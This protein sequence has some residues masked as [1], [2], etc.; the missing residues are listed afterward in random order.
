MKSAPQDPAREK[1]DQLYAGPL[2]GFVARRNELAKELALAGAKEAA[3]RVKALPKPVATAWVVNRLAQEEAASLTALRAA[4]DELRRAQARGDREALRRASE[5]RHELV[6]TL[7][8]RAGE[9]LREGGHQDSIQARQRIRRTLE[10][11]AA[12]GSSAALDPPPGRLHE[13][14]EPPGFET[15]LGLAGGAPPTPVPRAAPRELARSRRAATSDSAATAAAKKAA[16][17]RR[18]ELQR[19]ATVAAEL[20]EEARAAAREAE[21]ERERATRRAEDAER[22]AARQ[23][24]RL[25]QAR[26]ARDEAAAQRRVA[27]REAA[28]AAKALEKRRAELAAAQGRLR[29]LA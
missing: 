26:T 15:L 6:G 20:V 11:I 21:A 3:A 8:E 29:D 25:R 5:E 2:E 13:D 12:Y 9:L 28:V 16:A 17:A 18:L 23:E 24:E 19:A 22:A 10:A 1:L 14:V 4:G 27:E 7:V